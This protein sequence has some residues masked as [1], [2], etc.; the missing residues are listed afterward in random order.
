MRAIHSDGGRPRLSLMDA[1]RELGGNEPAVPPDAGPDARSAPSPDN[2]PDALPADAP[3]DTPPAP[4]DRPPPPP[5]RP[6]PDAG[7]TADAGPET[8][9]LP[10]VITDLFTEQGWFSDPTVAPS[11]A[12]GSMV[13]RQLESTDGPCA[14]RPPGARGRCLEI[15]YRPPTNLAPPSGGGWVGSYF[16]APLRQ[17]H[18]EQTPAARA[19]DPNWGLEAGLPVAAGAT[20]VSFYVTATADL[21]I[22][23]RVGSERDV[24]ILPEQTEA[25]TTTWTR[26]RISLAGTGYDRLV[27]PFAW[28]L[29]DTTTSARFYL[30]DLIWE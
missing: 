16:L 28:L 3:S 7:A 8:V 29:K 22:S 24:L 6:A 23:F 15:T 2:P 1:A 27:A 4:A 9:P 14:S 25:V 17:D 12:P 18:P 21:S 19:G 26:R 11:F 30:D 13:I 10:L 5:D 20:R